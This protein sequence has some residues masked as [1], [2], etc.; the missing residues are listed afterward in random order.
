MFNYDPN[1]PKTRGC[2]SPPASLAAMPSIY[3][4][5]ITPLSSLRP[6]GRAH[7]WGAS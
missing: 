7:A 4:A 6:A 3:L 2:P 5:Q 1:L